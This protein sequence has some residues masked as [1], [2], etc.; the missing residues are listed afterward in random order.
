MSSITIAL[1]SSSTP[2]SVPSGGSN[3]AIA[4]G[5][6]IAVVAVIIVGASLFFF[7][8]RR[9]LNSRVET[10]NK[11]HRV[12]ILDASHPASHVT[13]F[14]SRAMFAISQTHNH[15]GPRFSHRPGE[16]MKVASRRS[17]GGWDFS[18]PLDVSS[19]FSKS[20]DNIPSPSSTVF[21]LQT[22]KEHKVP[23][24]ITTRGYIEA[25]PEGLPPPAYCASRTSLGSYS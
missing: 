16:G 22:K 9:R 20:T 13:P 24:Q 15:D 3:A 4:V 7:L 8:R 23:G 25:D 11:G 19:P 14:P 1:S 6:A 10:S 21:S 2:S 17:D 12:T 5:V 18:Q